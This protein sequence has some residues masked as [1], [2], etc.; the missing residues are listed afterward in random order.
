VFPN[1]NEEEEQPVEV[2]FSDSLTE[3]L[4]EFLHAKGV[5][6]ELQEEAV[7]WVQERYA[8]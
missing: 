2:E 1:E 3:G 6:P 7:R 4:P 8:K 5:P